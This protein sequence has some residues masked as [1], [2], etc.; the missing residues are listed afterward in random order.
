[1]SLG[2]DILKG[3]Q[4]VCGFHDVI[5]KWVGEGKVEEFKAH[6]LAANSATF[7]TQFQGEMAKQQGTALSVQTITLKDSSPEAYNILIQLMYG[8]VTGLTSSQDSRLLFQVYGLAE[9][10]LVKQKIVDVIRKKVADLKVTQEKLISALETFTEFNG[11]E[12][13]GEISN[14]LMVKVLA[15][16]TKSADREEFYFN[17]IDNNLVEVK[18]LMKA[19]RG[20]KPADCSNCLVALNNCVDGQG[21][22]PN[23]VPHVGLRLKCMGAAIIIKS[24]AQAG[25]ETYNRHQ[26]YDVKVNWQYPDGTSE[27]ADMKYPVSGMVYM[28]KD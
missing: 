19:A 18:A 3:L 12:G 17:H 7:N 24:I 10:Y 22:L 21:I 13:F 28:C 14:K 8:D 20:F 23:K 6:M 16:L 2:D 15:K 11:L 26:A 9:K 1:M 25:S 27:V 5:F 4:E